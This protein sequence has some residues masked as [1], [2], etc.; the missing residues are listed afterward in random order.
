MTRKQDA[1][2]LD[3]LFTAALWQ[4]AGGCI[5]SPEIKLQKLM[6]AG[7]RGRQ[8]DRCWPLFTVSPADVLSKPHT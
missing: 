1:L 8:V 2:S 3:S 5:F 7:H 6:S 4:K